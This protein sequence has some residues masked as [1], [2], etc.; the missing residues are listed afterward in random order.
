MR[1]KEQIERYLDDDE[2]QKTQDAITIWELEYYL[3]NIQFL[4]P[5][6]PITEYGVQ[7]IL[8]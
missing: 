7:R 8:K 2:L 1:T 5:N 3:D 4:S 6:E